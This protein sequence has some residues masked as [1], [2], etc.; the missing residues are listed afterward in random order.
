MFKLLFAD[1]QAHVE[2]YVQTSN[3]QT[4]TFLGDMNLDGS[5]DVLGDAFTLIGNLNNPAAGYTQGDLNLDGRVDVLSDA[6]LL[7]GNLGKSNAASTA[8]Q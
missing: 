7:I 5:V 2:T 4:G 3:G 1:P 6:F 8:K